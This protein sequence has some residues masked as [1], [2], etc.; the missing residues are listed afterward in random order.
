M[1]PEAGGEPEAQRDPAQSLGAGS[2][3][4]EDERARIGRAMESR[5]QEES[6]THRT[7]HAMLT[8]I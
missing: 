7:G 1:E 3:V 5:E 8:G 6:K 4:G 2:K